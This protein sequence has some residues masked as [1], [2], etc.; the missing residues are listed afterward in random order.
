M[1]L[2]RGTRLGPY[3]IESPIG[4]GGMGEVYKA[5]DTRL[6]RTV[7]IKVL[8][9][10][11]ASDP[12]RKQRFEREA[13]TVA[14]LS[15]PH[16]CPVFDV[17]R[18]GEIDFLVMEYLEGETL[19][20]RLQKGALPLDQALKYAIEIADA[21][22]KAHR[23]GVTHRDLK[24]AN[25]MLTKAGAKLLDFGLAKLKQP[26]A[27]A[28]GM[29]TVPTQSAGLT[30]QG[31]ILGTLQYMAP[32]QLEGTEADARTDI[33]A[34]GALVYEMATRKKA[35]EG[36]SQ[37]SLIAAILEREPTPISTLQ[38][39]L[40]ERLDE[41]VRTCLA[42]DPD[43]RWQGA[44][45]L[46]RQLKIIQGGSQPSVAVPV[47][48][49]PQRASW[50]QA[51]AWAATALAVG[52]LLTGIAVWSLTRPAPPAPRPL[53]RFVVI[54]PPDGPLLRSAS[55]PE[56]AI[57]PDG[58]RIVYGS[59]TGPDSTRQ[60]YLR[61][62]DQ[63][64]ATPLRGTERG[65]APFFSPDGEWVG[66]RD[67][68]DTL[69]KV[70]VLGGPA[71]T[72]CELGGG[73]R[74]MSWASDDTI[75]FATTASNG[76]MRVPAVGGEPEVLTTVDPEGFET[77]HAWPEVLPNGKGVLFTAWSGSADGSRIAVVSLETGEITYLV[78][79]GSNPHYSPT[80][81]IVYGVGGT[82]RAVGFD[83]ERLELTSDNA[84]PV[85]EN[86]NTKSFSGAANF[87]LAGNGSLVY[88]AGTGFSGGT[89]R[90]LA[91]V[92]RQGMETA[93]PLPALGYLDP[94]LSP[95]GRR[96]AVGV[97]DEGRFDL[98][99]F[100]VQSAAG[101]RLTNEATVRTPIWTP[102]GERIIFS[103]NQEPPFAL[104]WIP[105]DGSGEAERLTTPDAGLVGDFPTSVSPDGQAV[106]F[107]RNLGA[108]NA[109]LWQVPL[110]GERTP[111]PVV[112]GEFNRGNASLS[113]DGQWLAYRSNQSGAFEVYLQPYPG[114]GSTTPVSIG[115]GDSAV[116]SRDGRE[117]FYRVGNR[118]MVVEVEPEPTLRVGP[119]EEL[120]EEPY[121]D[122]GFGSPRQYHVAP[123]GRFLMIRL[124]A[125]TD[126]ATAS[127]ELILV[128]NWFDELQRLVP[129]P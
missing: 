27:G 90:T 109:E 117:L 78:P 6:E 63:L 99:V 3:Q 1:P 67:A 9:A 81:H 102:D 65:N 124:G 40:P 24:P 127:P 116:W 128:Q 73:P 84:V 104:F 16:I 105:A 34:F 38:P 30:A 95:D 47:V 122:T 42:K 31:T 69:K 48:A 110:D 83:A 43:D 101:L 28:P 77:A 123:D 39:M 94:R 74:G 55:Y 92:D 88:V 82:L 13:K 112:Q 53:A 44:G 75:V 37:A 85:L 54:T 59:G 45:D 103:W 80:G 14:A 120:W 23:Q 17:G 68:A 7:A 56:V 119:P 107:T 106:V 49:T 4:A 15:H 87:S 57:S 93:L 62:V 12:E 64:D 114:P 21:L 97:A 18:E 51:M 113:P 5:T 111:Q 100:D 86:V 36:K 89:Q 96:V 41:I 129:T 52:S 98:W 79:G 125:T 2:E 72:I 8:P 108:G 70:S 25:I 126:D 32:E 19:A 121:Y 11:V 58:T 60:L 118:M 26:A 76:L 71:V 66:F 20:E 35:F 91:W 10:H 115:G 33:F 46:G 29:S 50:R 22:D 61:H